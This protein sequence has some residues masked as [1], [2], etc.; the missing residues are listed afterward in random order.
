M[1]SHPPL[2][3]IKTTFLISNSASLKYQY[4][5][6]HKCTATCVHGYIYINGQ[7][8]LSIDTHTTHLK[9]YTPSVLHVKSNEEHR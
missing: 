6:E 9:T 1:K 8:H 4:M 2:T 7:V 5:Q 3:S